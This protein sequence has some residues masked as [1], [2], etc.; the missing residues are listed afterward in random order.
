MQ[1]NEKKIIKLKEEKKKII[2]NVM[3]TETYKVAKKILDKFGIEKKQPV[4]TSDSPL[5]ANLRYN[6]TGEFLIML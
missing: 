4:Q 5:N 2:D 1:R 3:E 6:Q